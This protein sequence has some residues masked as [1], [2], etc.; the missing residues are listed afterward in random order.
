MKTKLSKR[1][2]CAVLC[3]LLALP[4]VMQVGAVGDEFYYYDTKSL[5]EF[6]GL[7]PPETESV[8]VMA[9]NLDSGAVIYEKNAKQ[10]LFP[11]S[12]VKIMTAIVALENINDLDTVIYASKNAVKKSSGTRMSPVNPI[13]E[14]EGFTARELLYALLVVGANDAANVLAEHVAGSIDDFCVMMNEKAKSIG[15]T[16]TVFKNPTGLHDEGMVTTAYDMAKIASY[17]YSINDI[18]KFAGTT[19]Y[20]IEKTEL[21]DVRRYLNNRN[22][23]ILRVDGQKDYFY[24]GVNG[25]SSGSTPQGGNCVIAT[26][27]KGSLSYLVVV[28]NAPEINE[29]NCAYTDAHAL[30]D[31]CF[32][33]FSVHKVAGEGTLQ[34][35]IPVSLSATTDHVT[36][37]AKEDISALLPNSVDI[38]NE[39]KLESLVY[40]D[41][42]APV[43]K[44]E[45]FGELVATYKNTIVLGRVELVSDQN[46]DRSALLFIL[47]AIASF[48]TGRWFLSM[49]FF[50]VILFSAY[51]YIYYR[52]MKRRRNYR[53]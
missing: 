27:K 11:A 31:F 36:L 49:L 29:V 32:N 20:V 21:T 22:R 3:L 45:T 12:T 10:I 9:V 7:T 8:S 23:L 6:A 25:L 46:I 30:L 26:A 19:N 16:D 17:A 44:G 33:N 35:E 43:S 38:K 13:K 51:C 50:A 14:G 37:L 39:I 42:K 1:L 41:A 40:E 53:H 48:F 15:A 4:L 28:M 5:Q 52:K 34:C 24:R 2:L 47:D 18:V